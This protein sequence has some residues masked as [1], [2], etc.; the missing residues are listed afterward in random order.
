MGATD[1]ASPAELRRSPFTVNLTRVGGH[2]AVIGCD[3]SFDPIVASSG[4][5]LPGENVIAN[6]RYHVMRPGSY[7]VP[8]LDAEFGPGL[9]IGASLCGRRTIA[10]NG[11]SWDVKLDGR[12]LCRGCAEQLR[13][14]P[15]SN[16]G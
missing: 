13:S 6:G 15:R 14:M 4:E 7:S 1:H 10:T 9:S 12:S 8:V 2:L 3:V 16:Y 11:V 5:R